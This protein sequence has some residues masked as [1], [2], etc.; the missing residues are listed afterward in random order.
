MWIEPSESGSPSI[1]VKPQ[2]LLGLKERMSSTL[3]FQLD[4]AAFWA[5]AIM[6][7]DA[8]SLAVCKALYSAIAGAR[9]KGLTWTQITVT[10]E[11]I[12]V[13]VLL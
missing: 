11:L 7:L 6:E 8:E 3:P 5:L 4:M 1:A 10:T 2:V 13:S 9:V 12:H